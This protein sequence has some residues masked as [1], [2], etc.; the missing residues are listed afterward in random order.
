MLK[1]WLLNNPFYFD[2]N[3]G[4]LYI[5][6]FNFLFG[7]NEKKDSDYNNIISNKKPDFKFFPNNIYLYYISLTPI[8]NFGYNKFN[9]NNNNSFAYYNNFKYIYII[10]NYYIKKFKFIVIF[11]N[12]FWLGFY[13]KYS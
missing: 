4:N 13:C 3:K 6:N 9:N 7:Y 2:K 8:E 12:V 10:T 1:P 11:S 5:F